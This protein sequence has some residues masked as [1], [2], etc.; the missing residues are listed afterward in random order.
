MNFSR[1]IG[2][3]IFLSFVNFYNGQADSN[4]T[5]MSLSGYL[6]VF[7][8]YDLNTPND[9]RQPFVF[10][11]NRHNALNLNLGLIKLN[12][13]HDKYR[14]NLGLQAGTYAQDNYAAEPLMYRSINEAN[15]GLALNKK[16]SIWLD[17][18]I[19]S[20]HLG[21]E[22]AIGVDNLTLSR[23][24]TAESSPYFL[25][26]IKVTHQVNSQLTYALIASNGWQRIQ[27]VSG[28]NWIST[29][30]QLIYLPSDKVSLNWSTFITSEDPDSTR[31]MMYFNNLYI[32]INWNDRWTS[33][34]GFDYGVKQKNK[35][36]SEY[37]NW[38][39]S[40]FITQYK[41]KKSWSMAIRG[42]Y[43]YD[44]TNIIINTGSGNEF[45]TYG[46]SFNLDRKIHDKITWRTEIRTFISNQDNFL[47]G[48]IFVKDNTVIMSSLAI[49][50]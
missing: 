27:R 24:L 39:N 30:T 13:E 18:G 48:N 38:Y 35:S 10:N 31:R 23:S 12:V 28:N 22:S 7:Y 25:S 6:D 15:I 32:Q 29:G 45:I 21:F 4:Q 34:L 26:G 5:K 3:L 17:A 44:P 9:I 46:L 43:F 2:I 42:E 20:S 47:K 14:A 8:A 40:T 11:Y 37:N 16:S 36:S 1:I 19:F 33:I 49:K 50:L 41:F